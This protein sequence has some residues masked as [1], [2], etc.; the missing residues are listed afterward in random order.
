MC[1]TFLENSLKHTKIHEPVPCKPGTKLRTVQAQ[2]AIKKKKEKN[3]KLPLISSSYKNAYLGS[4]VQPH[5][6]FYSILLY[7][8]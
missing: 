2:K 4:S 8:Y 5:S 6:A 3:H 1:I 7:C